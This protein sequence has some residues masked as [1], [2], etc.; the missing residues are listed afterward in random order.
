MKDVILAA[1][2]ICRTTRTMRAEFSRNIDLQ[3]QQDFAKILP[4]VGFFNPAVQTPAGPV[5]RAFFFARTGP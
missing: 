1:W 2:N 4:I 3:V 5:R